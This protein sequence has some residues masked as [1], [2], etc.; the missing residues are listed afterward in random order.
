[1][2]RYGGGLFIKVKGFVPRSQ[3]KAWLEH[4]DALD[5]GDCGFDEDAP[6]GNS[7]PK[8]YDGVTGLRMIKIMLDAAIQRLPPALRQVVIYRWIDKAQR[9]VILQKTGLSKDTYYAR[10]DQAVDTVWQDVNGLAPN[11]QELAAA[12]KMDKL[13]RAEQGKKLSFVDAALKNIL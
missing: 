10:C 1:M 6:P 9:S 8:E 13:E 12:I 11:Y 3:V 4:Y 7:G 5:A 2:L